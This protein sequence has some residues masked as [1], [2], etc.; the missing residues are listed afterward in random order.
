MEIKKK[1]KKTPETVNSL[2]KKLKEEKKKIK[3]LIDEK[4]HSS[5]ET[6][7]LYSLSARLITNR[8]EDLLSR[9]KNNLPAYQYISEKIEEL[10]KLMDKSTSNNMVDIQAK[11][12]EKIA[13]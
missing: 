7:K 6:I 4:K 10:N 13:G 3:G 9:E 1:G 11:A 5:S 2:T 12:E 8:V